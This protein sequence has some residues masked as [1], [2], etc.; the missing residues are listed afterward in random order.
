[1]TLIERM[2]RVRV[3]AFDVDGVLT[4][5]G[6]HFDERGRELKTFSARDG[7]GF[8]LLKRHGI[9]I[10]VITGR[11]SSIVTHRMAALGADCV[12]QGAHDKHAALD[13]LLAALAVDAEQVSFLGDDLIDLPVLRRVGLAVT[14]ADG[15]PELDAHVHLR[16]NARGGAGAARELIEQILRAQLGLDALGAHFYP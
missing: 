4:D 2:Q 11:S 1:M 6:L 5:G 12:I 16:L 7:L 14:V 13:Q 15:H 9:R 3:A 8:T 10:G